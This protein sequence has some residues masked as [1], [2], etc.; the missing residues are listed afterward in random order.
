MTVSVELF[1]QAVIRSDGNL[2]RAGHSFGWTQEKAYRFIAK[3]R[4][5]WFVNEVR[6]GA[7]ATRPIVPE[8]GDPNIRRAR[9]GLIGGS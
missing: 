2:L 7:V 5:R 1:K 8:D 6:R 3:H 9:L 4:L